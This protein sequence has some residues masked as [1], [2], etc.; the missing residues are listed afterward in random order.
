MYS[1]YKN[2][3][4][5][6][7]NR[8]DCSTYKK[9]ELQL[10][11]S[12]CLHRKP[13]RNEKKTQVSTDAKFACSQRRDQDRGGGQG[14]RTFRL[15]PAVTVFHGE[16]GPDN[17]RLKTKHTADRTREP[18]LPLKLARERKLTGKGQTVE[19]ITKGT[20]ITLL[21]ILN[22]I[23][24]SNTAHIPLRSSKHGWTNQFA[25][26]FAACGVLGNLQKTTRVRI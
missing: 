4:P 2:H 13:S 16:T 25:F 9:S 19:R 17:L 7:V 3:N 1:S 5:K 12:L 22:G 18:L 6:C 21:P 14:P 8:Q 26:I 15:E 10:T 23:A 24:T 11:R 20:K